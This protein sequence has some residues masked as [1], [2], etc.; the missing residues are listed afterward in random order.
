[1][2]SLVI[3]WKFLHYKGFPYIAQGLFDT[4]LE[5]VIRSR[6]ARHSWASAWRCPSRDMRAHTVVA[7]VLQ[8]ISEVAPSRQRTNAC[9]LQFRLDTQA[10]WC[11]KKAYIVWISV[12]VVLGLFFFCESCL[13]KIE[14]NCSKLLRVILSKEIYVKFLMKFD[15]DFSWYFFLGNFQEISSVKKVFTYCTQGFFQI[16]FEGVIRSPFTPQPFCPLE[17]RVLARVRVALL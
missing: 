11:T 9:C 1:M 2:F 10:S 16:G 15:L 7:A 17:T 3:P 4:D 12:N 6:T 8:R 14:K 13:D 5:G